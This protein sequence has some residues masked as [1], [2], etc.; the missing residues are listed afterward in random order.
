[1]IDL[2]LLLEEMQA[3]C[4]QDAIGTALAEAKTTPLV[5]GTRVGHVNLEKYGQTLGTLLTINETESTVEV[6][7][8][9]KT[10]ET[11][12]MVSIARFNELVD[13][14]MEK[15]MEGL[16]SILSASQRNN[17]NPEGNDSEST[18]PLDTILEML[19]GTKVGGPDLPTPGCDCPHCAA[20]PPEKHEE[21]RRLAEE[22]NIDLSGREAARKA[23]GGGGS[24]A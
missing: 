10:W 19:M 14:G 12:G 8:E 11:D 13:D 7:G 3:A 24:E 20:F 2:L 21:A 18:S 15:A 22:Q 1:M 17:T 23:G 4:V 9:T 16:K 5:A 6:E